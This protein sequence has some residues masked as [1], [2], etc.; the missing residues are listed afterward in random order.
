MATKTYPNREKPKDNKQILLD[1][2]SKEYGVHN[3][4]VMDKA[5]KTQDKQVEEAMTQGGMTATDI[6][7]SLGIDLSSL[8]NK[9]QSQVSSLE[10]MP[11]QTTSSINNQSS[12]TTSTSK[13]ASSPFGFGGV[14]MQNGQVIEQQ[15][16]ILAALLSTLA[17]GNPKTSATLDLQRLLQQSKIQ[18]APLETQAEQRRL[19]G[20][21]RRTKQAERESIRQ[22]G[23]S[24]GET[25][26]PQLLNEYGVDVNTMVE[27]YGIPAQ[28][29]KETGERRW[30]LPD[31]YTQS[32]MAKNKPTTPEE[33]KY[34]G[35]IFNAVDTTQEILSDLKDLG[36]QDPS[37]IGN[38]EVPEGFWS[39]MGPMSIP[40]KF[41]LAG[42]YA[43]DPKYSALKSKIE[44]MFQQ[45]RIVITG[46]QASDKE[47]KSLRPLII[48]MTQR[49]GVFFATANDLMNESTRNADTRLQLMESAGR[50]T[51]K[52][53]EMLNTRKGKKA[54]ASQTQTQEQTFNIAGKTYRI[55][56]DKV[57]T[58]KKAKGIH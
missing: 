46:A 42:Q 30:N 7:K 54:E 44:R 43:K 21:E 10:T 3:A 57:E 1:L 29:D 50:D 4:I 16:G 40:A 28:I 20:E 56:A 11:Q 39:D 18:Q 27:T 45:Y 12:A 19:T 17:T 36:I 33:R 23:R 2:I 32:T 34:L 13:P 9:T 26:I 38:F 48:S 41:N 8:G 25:E 15:P 37:Q 22:F 6:G 35:D 51:S 14:S 58:F 49:P 55:P 52:I 47:L 31:M 53:R 5:L 24:V